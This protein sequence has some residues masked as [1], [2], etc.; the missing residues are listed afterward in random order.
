MKVYFFLTLFYFVGCGQ[1]N[2]IKK[3]EKLIDNH[4]IKEQLIDVA[5]PPPYLHID[6]N[7]YNK[8]SA[9]K[10]QI[11]SDYVAMLLK[12]EHD[13]LK[14]YS[15]KYKVVA[16]DNVDAGLLKGYR[17][18]YE[19]KSQVYYMVCD[20]KVVTH[21]IL[22]ENDKIISFA[23]NVFSSH[24]GRIEPFMLDSLKD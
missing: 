11:F 12:L 1:N 10:Q 7:D 3:I 22:D 18:V 15:F 8:L 16:H 6:R 24:G 20:N 5:N 2:N 21:F 14:K 19:D 9:D 23:P 13:E 17:L 4:F